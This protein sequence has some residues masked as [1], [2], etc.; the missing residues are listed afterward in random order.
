MAKN[1]SVQ[2]INKHYA[3]RHELRKGIFGALP[4]ANYGYWSREGMAID[5]ACDALTDLMA[6]EMDLEQGDRILECGC[7]YGASAVYIATHYKPK[8]IVGID[9]TEIRIETGR[10]LIEENHL[11][12]VIQ[13]ETGDATK[14]QFDAGSFNKV[15]A[16]ECAFHF[17]TRKAFFGEAFRVLAPGGL[18]VM[19]DII[20]SPEINFSD[21]TIEELKK[22]IS[23]DLKYYCEDN[24]YDFDTYKD[25]LKEVGFDQIKTYSIKDKVI[26][27]FADHL[28]KVAQKS[29]SDK[30]ERRMQ[31]AERFRKQFMAGG[32]YIVVR[33]EKP[34]V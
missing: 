28:E 24:I 14:L 32:D 19:T 12:D 22:F 18:L 25:Y 20:V 5:D 26:L 16:I 6:R 27:Q 30:R 31:E 13:I 15:L 7:G 10:K 17:N 29:P 4:Y 11:Q 23:A 8:K 21:H 9:A 3:K 34:E 33:A 2:D 1:Y